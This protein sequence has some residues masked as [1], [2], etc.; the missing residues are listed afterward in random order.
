MAVD[1]AA[2]LIGKGEE[3][4][5]AVAVDDGGQTLHLTVNLDGHGLLL[6][7]LGKG[8]GDLQRGLGRLKLAYIA[9]ERDLHGKFPPNST[10][11]LSCFPGEG[12]RK[13]PRPPCRKILQKGRGRTYCLC[14]PRGSTQIAAHPC[15]TA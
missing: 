4:Q 3:L 8:R 10:F 11:F 6:E 5:R 12:M 9:L 1:A 13:R 14:A 7:R 2:L 15:A